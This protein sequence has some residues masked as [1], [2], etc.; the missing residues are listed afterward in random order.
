VPL[1]Q[2]ADS[3]EVDQLQQRIGRRFDPEQARLRPDRRLHLREVA[4]IDEPERETGRALAYALEQAVGAAV[5]IVHAQHVGAAVEE[6]ENRR[7][8]G[9]A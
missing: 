5:E 1:R 4:E 3:L 2:H 6:I 7:R 8:A 9:Q